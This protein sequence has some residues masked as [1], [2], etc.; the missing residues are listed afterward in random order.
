MVLN[1]A[2]APKGMGRFDDALSPAEVDCKRVGMAPC[3]GR[4]FTV[5][6]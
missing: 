2:Y 4:L 6:A 1:G 5:G 3:R